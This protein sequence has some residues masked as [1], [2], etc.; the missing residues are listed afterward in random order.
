MKIPHKIRITQKVTYDIVWVDRFDDPNQLGWCCEVRKQICI[1]KGMSRADTLETFNH[2]VLHAIEFEYEI[3][4]KVL[5]HRA[6][7]ALQKP[8]TNI[9]ILNNMH[10][11]KK[12]TRRKLKKKRS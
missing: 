4:S 2:E 7:Y 12:K 6:I 3:P 1:K 11:R 8:L 9:S 5:T 10:Y